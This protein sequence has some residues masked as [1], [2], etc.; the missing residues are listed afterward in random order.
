M[1][2]ESCHLAVLW[3]FKHGRFWAPGVGAA[4]KTASVFSQEAGGVRG[5]ASVLTLKF[6]K[7]K[8]KLRDFPGGPAVKNSSL[9]A[10]GCGFNP[11]L[12][13]WDSHMPCGPQIR[14]WNRSN[15]ITHLIKGFKKWFPFK[16]KIKAKPWFLKSRPPSQASVAAGGHSFWVFASGFSHIPWLHPA[17]AVRIAAVLLGCNPV[18]LHPASSSTFPPTAPGVC[19]HWRLLVSPW[20]PGP[21][22]GAPHQLGEGGLLGSWAAGGLSA[23]GAWPFLVRARVLGWGRIGALFF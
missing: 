1:V 19:R 11:W 8:S 22:R 5:E 3:F 2:D 23:Q 4:S 14:T 18:T 13:S 12:G 6:I 16:K 15:M 10:E 7:M 20:G 17:D 9:H 21:C